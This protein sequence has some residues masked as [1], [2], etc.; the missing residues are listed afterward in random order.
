[1]GKTIVENIR[2]FFTD[3]RWEK[4]RA[5]FWFCVI[6]IAIHLGWRFWSIQLHSWPLYDLMLKWSDFFVDTVYRQS[7]W[8]ISNV[9][10]IPITKYSNVMMCENGYGLS[11]NDSCS[12]IKQIM[13]FVLLMLI[14]PGPWK[15][16]TWFIPLGVIVVHFTNVLRIILLAVVALHS[17]ENIKS[18]HDSYLRIMFYVV[19]F[20]LW[21]LW[22]EKIS[23]KKPVKS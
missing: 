23:V 8:F 21:L 6:T 19:I 22:V 16:K 13:Q 7:T 17:P 18:V 4:V 9:L 10:K 11:V 12:G 1:M 15:H 14:F 5:V 20:G 3:D 2:I